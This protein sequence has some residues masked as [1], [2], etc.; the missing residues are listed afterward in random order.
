MVVVSLQTDSLFTNA[1]VRIDCGWDG[2]A[3]MPD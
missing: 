3:K 2:W 1:R